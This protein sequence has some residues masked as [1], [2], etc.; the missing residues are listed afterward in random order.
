VQSALRFPEAAFTFGLKNVLLPLLF[1]IG[2]S[3]TFVTFSNNE[4]QLSASF[5]MYK[6]ATFEM[7]TLTAKLCP[8]VP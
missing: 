2:P 7:L 1:S 4:F 5:Q 6:S 8:A 3:M